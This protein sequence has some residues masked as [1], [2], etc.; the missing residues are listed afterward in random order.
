MGVVRPCCVL[1]IAA[2]MEQVPQKQ[3]DYPCDYFTYNRIRLR[4]CNNEMSVFFPNKVQEA[5]TEK[6]G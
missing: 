6:E 2:A 4:D 3:P 1:L 5:A